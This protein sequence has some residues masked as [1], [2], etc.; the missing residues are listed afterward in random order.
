VSII[1]GFLPFLAFAVVS[2]T[3]GPIVALIVGAAVS[4]ALI[5]RN[6]ARGG[7]DSSGL[8]CDRG[9]ASGGFS[10][11]SL[12]IKPSCRRVTCPGHP[13]PRLIRCCLL[14][15]VAKQGDPFQTT[16]EAA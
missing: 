14:S 6:R 4:A 2:L 11:H 15:V 5:I 9:R 7:C 1:L 13:L 3:A 10:V 16:K 8:D 12:A